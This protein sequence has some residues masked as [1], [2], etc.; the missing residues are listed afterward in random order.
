MRM[1]EIGPG[2]ECIPGFETYGEG[3]DVDHKGDARRLPFQDG[4]FDVVYSS[5]CIEHIP[6]Y[7]VEAT[8]NEWQRVVKPGGALEV[9][10]VDGYKIMKALVH[11]EETG[12]WT[13]PGI[14]PWKEKLTF[15]DPYKWAV[16]RI[17]NYPKRGE[18]DSWL[19]RAILTPEYLQRV[20]REIGLRNVGPLERPRAK[21]HGW[22]NMGFGGTKP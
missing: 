20:L 9:W 15:R 10:T 2:K 1:L 5:H 21:D 17:L 19:H 22:I 12:E 3:G 6:W 11:L 7:Q 4:T 14:G 16:G 18:Y 8:L 13:G